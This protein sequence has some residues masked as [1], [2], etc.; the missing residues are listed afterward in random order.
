MPKLWVKG[1]KETNTVLKMVLFSFFWNSFGL[2][3]NVLPT[4]EYH[5][6]T[7][8]LVF[9]AN[10]DVSEIRTNGTKFGQKLPLHFFREASCLDF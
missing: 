5:D 2:V 4:V 6:Y 1:A 8:D 10:S 3:F 9:V 7:K